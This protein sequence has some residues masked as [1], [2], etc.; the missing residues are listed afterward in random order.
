M[1]AEPPAALGNPSQP[2]TRA[3][4]DMHKR[5]SRAQAMA[6]RELKLLASVQKSPLLPT[7]ITTDRVVRAVTK[8]LQAS[9][10]GGRAQREMDRGGSRSIAPPEG[11]ERSVEEETGEERN[12]QSPQTQEEGNLLQS[13]PHH[14]PAPATMPA[15]V[16]APPDSFPQPVSPLRPAADELLV[17]PSSSRHLPERKVEQAWAPPP[18]AIMV[19]QSLQSEQQA[20]KERQFAPRA[21]YPP[22]RSDAYTAPPLRPHNKRAPF[23]VSPPP[24]DSRAALASR[25]GLRMTDREA[26]D[27][28]HWRALAD[29]DA[30]LARLHAQMVNE[31]MAAAVP[32]PRPR[33]R[34][35]S[36]K[37]HARKRQ[38]IQD[39][40][41][42]FIRRNP[43]RPP[44][45]VLA[46]L[47]AARARQQPSQQ[48]AAVEQKQKPSRTA[49]PKP[50]PAGAP[51]PPE[52]GGS[53]NPPT[54]VPSRADP[55]PD[56]QRS[57]AALQNLLR[58]V[59]ILEQAHPGGSQTVP[60]QTHAAPQ[61]L[62][63]SPPSPQS[64]PPPTPPVP[65]GPLLLLAPGLVTRL[66]AERKALRAAQSSALGGWSDSPVATDAYDYDGDSPPTGVTTYAGPDPWVALDELSDRWTR[67]DGARTH[68]QI[69]QA[70][71]DEATDTVGAEIHALSDEF[72]E[73]LF[74]EEFLP[75]PP[76]AGE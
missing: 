43:T 55:T 64:P 30:R 36:K 61:T 35:P 69:T 33:A 12:L 41:E 75:A 71:L 65:R 31:Q 63:P 59:E 16:P 53:Q 34:P 19:D 23:S 13:P 38:S 58:I 20:T 73:R 70:L 11:H 2:P 48:N 45:A 42:S 46:E 32:R 54:T 66:R 25:T 3:K 6:Q 74:D 17:E 21:A 27:A 62:P 14:A 47:V 22:S 57:E 26:T 56:L 52:A 7:S 9:L 51:P 8:R 68:A 29:S 40:W 37:Q 18:P 5:L 72:V 49:S 24:A 67:A 1:H 28:D 10:N 60:S 50:A 15:W 44:S 4:R 39:E 76:A